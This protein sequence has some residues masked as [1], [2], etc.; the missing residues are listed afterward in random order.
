MFAT[1]LSP[2][3]RYWDWLLA[4]IRGLD[5]MVIMFTVVDIEPLRHIEIAFSQR[6]MLMTA[7]LFLSFSPHHRLPFAEV[8]NPMHDNIKVGVELES[9]FRNSDECILEERKIWFFIFTF[10]LIIMFNSDSHTQ[11]YKTNQYSD[12]IEMRKLCKEVGLFNSQTQG[13][14]ANVNRLLR[15]CGKYL[16]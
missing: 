11:P 10:L 4:C 9:V 16:G 1:V 13:I 6:C 2:F 15:K 5:V 8:L 14:Q 12:S 7:S 3:S